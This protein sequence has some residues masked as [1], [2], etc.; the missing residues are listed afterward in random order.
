MVV[1]TSMPMMC[2]DSSMKG[3]FLCACSCQQRGLEP[4]KQFSGKFSLLVDPANDA[5][6]FDLQRTLPS[7]FNGCWNVGA[8]LAYG[9]RAQPFSLQRLLSCIFFFHLSS[10][11]NSIKFI[12][13]RAGPINFVENKFFQLT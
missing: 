11:E 7:E 6:T 2:K 1:P 10:M 8:G 5:V 12:L 9:Y 3:K 4:R 13:H